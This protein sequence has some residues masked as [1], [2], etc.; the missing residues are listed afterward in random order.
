MLDRN[1]FRSCGAATDP[2]LPEGLTWRQLTD[3]TRAVLQT[4]GCRGWSIGVYN[5]DLDPDSRDAR[6]IV[7]YLGEVSG[8]RE[9]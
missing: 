1:E 9:T 4:D 6:R 2:S 3:L 5:A 7:A 8:A